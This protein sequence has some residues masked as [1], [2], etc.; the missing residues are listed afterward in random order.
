MTRLSL[1]VDAM[2]GDF[3][4]RVTVPA[5]LQALT[6]H[7]FLTIHLVGYPEVIKPLL[8]KT[9]HDVRQRVSL[10][11]AKSVIASDDKPSRA[12]KSGDGSSMRIALEL[13]QQGM[14]DACISAGNTGALMSLATLIIKRVESIKRP[15]LMSVVPHTG[16]GQTAV[17][18]LGANAQADS[19]ML[20]QFAMMG[21][22]YAEQ[23]LQIPKPRIALLNI[24]HE[25]D[26]GPNFVRKAAEL[27]H[28][29]SAMNYVGFV[30]G[31]E[32]LQ[33]KADVLVCDGFSGNIALKTIEGMLK[34]L[35]NSKIN[36]IGRA[37][38]FNSIISRLIKMR[39]A[40][41]LGP[42]NPDVYNGA[43]LLGLRST[44]IKSHGSANQQAFKAAIE[45]TVHAVQAQIPAKIAGRL[46]TVIARSDIA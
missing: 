17:L 40:R 11:E 32:L 18:D 27:L 24:G 25:A 31:N 44:V 46:Q 15:A 21:A 34:I 36:N 9:D 19:H 38:L 6:C 35:L 8:A 29:Q 7:K 28:Q 10:V 5:V 33:G 1:A 2:G 45:Q 12:V 41:Q 26:K 22:V 20:V 42:V 14:A 37:G 3:G 39:L 4:P 43:T 16:G 23:I 30:E 13:V